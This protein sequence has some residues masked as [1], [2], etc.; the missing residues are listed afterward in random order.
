M[1][2]LAFRNGAEKYLVPLEAVRAV[3]RLRGMRLLAGA[4]GTLVGVL[5][6]QSTPVA[7]HESRPAG[8]P[9]AA[10][11]EQAAGDVMVLADGWPG[12]AVAIACDEVLGLV[13]VDPAATAPAISGLPAYVLSMHRVDDALVPVVD[14]LA[15]TAQT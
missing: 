2:L 3:V 13:E 7:V 10:R 4:P 12:A 5:D 6:V 14:P 8:G 11:D 15:L 1:T 9:D